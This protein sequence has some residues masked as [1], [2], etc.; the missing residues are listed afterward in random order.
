[1]STSQPEPHDPEGAAPAA[2]EHE[3]SR[4][5]LETVVGALPLLLFVLDQDSVFTEF[6]IGASAVPFVPPERFLGRRIPEVLPDPPARMLADAVARARN[7]GTEVTVEYS[8]P[9]PAGEGSFEARIVPLGTGRVAVLVVEVSERARARELLGAKL[10]Q[11]S[12]VAELGQSAIRADDLQELLDQAVRVIAETLDVEYAKVLECGPGGETLLLRA[13]WG[14]PP[15]VVGHARVGAGEES[16]AGY[17]LRSK[18]PVA[19]FDLGTETRF[20]FAPLLREYGVASG[21]SIVIGGRDHPYGVLGAHSTWRRQFTEDEI[22]FLQAIAN[23][24]AQAVERH[25]ILDRQRESEERFRLLIDRSADLIGVIGLDGVFRFAGASVERVLGYRPEELVGRSALDWVHPEDREVALSRLALLAGTPGLVTRLTMRYRHQ[26]GSYRVLETSGINLAHVPAVA[27]IVLN[28]RDVTDRYALQE[29][30]SQ[31]QRLESVG[32]LAGG[33]AHDVNN[34]LTAILGNAELLAPALSAGS[35][36]QEE[37]EE[38]VRSSLRARD[39][40]QQL[41]AF[42]RKQVLAP[43]VLDLNRSVR[44]S[45]RLLRRVLRADITLRLQLTEP[46]WPVLADPAQVEQVLVNL[47]VN[48]RDAMP[49]GGTLTIETANVELD[50]GF[51]LEHH[52]AVEPGP[53]VM[54]AVRDTGVGMPPDVLAHAFEPFYTTKPQGAGTGLGLSTTYGI[55]KQSGGH[56][57]AESE[58]GAGSTFRVYFPRSR[59][60]VAENAEP[61]V[62]PAQ[63]GEETVLLVED[64]ESVSAISRR[65]L[66]RAG[67]RV[68]AAATP[69]EAL[70]LEAGYAEPI[71]LLLADVV[72]P[73]MSGREMAEQLCARR[74]GLSVLYISGYA[75]DA[76]AHHGVVEPGTDFLAKPFTAGTLV[77]K[78]REVLD[79]RER[80][81]G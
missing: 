41:L 39:L 66:E 43:R 14:W 10:R 25:R 79:A 27:G 57:Y 29:Q 77:A 33:V 12:A 78:V 56:I 69:E 37:L 40:V 30:L 1:M 76:I 19:V 49:T 26:D 4:G 8:L 3:L 64:D 50:P 45:E 7:S 62:P 38:I 46:L 48:A 9:T 53:H 24:L 23:I 44:N 80:A 15:G 51:A 20:R 2:G 34:I 81:P 6:R 59:E 74:R 16:Q 18:E 55:V 61:L 47:A 75:D 63:G 65:V 52:D 13:G 17:T 32:R 68:L 72:M 54:L 21:V 60:P 28:S 58:V 70:T 5:D 35:E 36:E 22:L 73:G 71:H 67:Y 11:Q 31:S 42:A